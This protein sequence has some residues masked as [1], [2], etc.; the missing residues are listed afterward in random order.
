MCGDYHYFDADTNKCA[1]RKCTEA[2]PFL[3]KDG[4]CTADC[5]KYAE[6][7]KVN[8]KCVDSCP[9][10]THEGKFCD[11]MCGD[12][13]YF[14]ADTNKCATRKC[15]EATPFLKKDGSCTTDCPKYAENPKVNAKCVDSCP[16]G[17]HEGKFCDAMCDDYAFYDHVD[18]KCAIRVCTETKP[19]LKRD[20]SCTSRCLKYAES[21]Q[22]DAKCVESCPQGKSVNDFCNI[23]CQHYEHF[24]ESIGKCNTPQC[25]ET[26]PFLQTDG[27]C[28]DTCPKYATSRGIGAKCVDVCGKGR[29]APSDGF[30]CPRFTLMADFG[31]CLPPVCTAKQK[32]TSA[33]TCV[34]S[35]PDG[36]A[37]SEASCHIAKITTHS[38]GKESSQ[39][40]LRSDGSVQCVNDAYEIVPSGLP[41]GSYNSIQ[42]RTDNFAGLKIDGSLSFTHYKYNSLSSI[43][44]DIM[45]GMERNN[46]LE[47][48]CYVEKTNGFV[49]CE[50][51]VDSTIDIYGADVVPDNLKTEKFKMVSAGCYNSCGV[52]ADTRTLK[53]WGSDLYSNLHK[54]PQIAGFDYVTVGMYS[55]CG[56]LKNGTSLCWNSQYGWGSYFTFPSDAD[57]NNVK[58]IHGL[59]GIACAL[60]SKGTIQCNYNMD[61][62]VPLMKLPM[63]DVVDVSFG[64]NSFCALSQ[65]GDSKCWNYQQST[66]V[67]SVS[68]KREAFV[69]STCTL[70]CNDGEFYNRDSYQCEACASNCHKCHNKDTCDQCKDGYYKDNNEC[71][72]CTDNC[73]KCHNKDTCEQCKNGYYIMD[74]GC[75]QEMDVIIDSSAAAIVHAEL[76]RNGNVVDVNGNIL[77]HQPYT[78]RPVRDKDTLVVYCVAVISNPATYEVSYHDDCP[79][80]LKFEIG[81][82]AF[83]CYAS[84]N[85]NSCLHPL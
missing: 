64:F 24:D 79:K 28:T 8:A 7:P 52:R 66:F 47:H 34:N 32:I 56:V 10:G 80:P 29:A 4:S 39:C 43:N 1:T 41:S 5:P 57:S 2:T 71:A 16:G 48:A 36:Q 72:R 82:T 33:G 23:N 63:T 15:T 55:A 19:F 83:G 38:K 42:G 35:C 75:G 69:P 77:A 49:K 21:P 59:R 18:K 67:E 54:F 31:V 60:S 81:G 12:Y 44:V 26:K 61:K 9:G 70:A 13:H 74:H 3:K 6:N 30:C 76:K 37:C 85:S 78:I 14:D 46:G 20:G 22:T 62:T 11:A 65:N 84:T 25:T 40:A 27:T 68:Y 45:P 51:R 17:T 53:C 50:K 73:E 58:I